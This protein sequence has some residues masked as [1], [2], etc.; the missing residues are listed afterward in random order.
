[1]PLNYQSLRIT[2]AF[3]FS[4]IGL[5]AYSSDE[6][7]I[8]SPNKRLTLTIEVEN[9]N[10]EGYGAALFS[11]NYADGKATKSILSRAALGMETDRQTFRNLKL[12]SVSEAMPVIEDYRMVTGKKSHCTNEGVERTYR[13]ENEQQQTLQVTFRLYND[14]VAFC[15]TLDATSVDTE[16]ITAELTTYPIADG[17]KRWMQQYVNDY[18]GFFPLSTNGE[19][20]EDRS[21]RTWGYPALVEPQE[22]VF[23]LIS[24]AGI[25]KNRSASRLNNAD[26]PNEYQVRMADEK[27]AFSGSF[28]TPWRT[29]II[30][31]LADVVESTLITDVSE[32]C[33]VTNTDWINPGSAAWIYWAH[34]HG[35]KDFQVVK[36]YIDLAA[37]MKWPYNLI[38]WEWDVM[39]NGGTV[40]DAIKYAQEK[41]VKTM[42]WY[43]SGTSWN[44]PGAPGP[45][46]RLYTN[47]SR[48]KEFAW[49]KELGVS[50]IKVDFFAVDGANIIN[51][52]IDILED[53]AKYQMMINFHGASIPRGWQR[54]YP[55]MM[56]V[57]AVYG[58]EWYNNRPTLTDRA[59]AH[60]ATLPFTRNVIG[61]MDYT[62]GTFT[63]SQHPH[64]TS[65]AHELA[66]PVIFESAL[67]HMPDRPSAYEALPAD[68]R[69]FLTGLPT[70]WDE[71]KL[72]GG[73]PGVDVIIARRKGNTWYIGGLNG[74]DEARTLTFSPAALTKSGK[75]I[76][77]FKDGADNKSFGIESARQL[78]DN[79]PITV[80]CLPRGGFVAL[81]K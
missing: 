30:G 39:G 66:L 74:T 46:D 52:Y 28:S 55:H 42:L 44:G 7:E 34:N 2:F 8:Q 62:P 40:Q 65:Y 49:L 80:E 68:I 50:G 19:D 36:E 11:I 12:H 63:D 67:Q 37:N 1:M 14:G 15:Y 64:I 5:Y 35:S 48:E 18:E 10:P 24:E 45:L 72:L 31:S 59:A 51:Y 9:A 73:Y 32:P 58:A 27:V 29:L 4:V 3:L 54:T 16:Y 76:T 53:A 17:A 13:F 69:E 25:T 60:N 71:T 57:E 22:S 20:V 61:P 26:N 43:N 77:F 79:A 81:I 56:T 70:A 41:G 6:T 23:M 21:P 78:T 33:K 38:D 75:T 47:E